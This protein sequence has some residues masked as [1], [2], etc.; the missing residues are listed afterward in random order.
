MAYPRYN[1]YQASESRAPNETERQGTM[2]P[3][4][5]ILPVILSGGAG[6]RLWPISRRH[7]PKQ[8]L[9]I[10]SD[11]PLI[12]D[13]VRRV[14]DA[15]AFRPPM[16]IANDAHRF[17]I[18]QAMRD[19]ALPCGTIALEP[20]GRNTAAS[21]CTAALIAAQ[22]GTDPLLLVLPSDHLIADPKA[23][24]SAIETGR[25]AAEAGYLTVFGIEPSAPETG[26]GYIKAGDTLA[27]APG[28]MHVDTFIEKPDPTRAATLLS[29]GGWTW[30]SGMFLLRA[31]SAIDAFAVHAP[32]ILA[33]CTE[34]VANAKSD[35]D[36]LRLGTAAWNDIP[37]LPFD[38]AVMEKTD[39][40]CVVPADMGWSDIGTWSAL[41]AIGVRDANGNVTRGDIV[42]CESNDSLAV[43]DGPLVALLGIDNLAVI[44]T[45]DAVLV[46]PK[47]RAQD[48]KVLVDKLAQAGRKELQTSA[49]VYRPWGHYQDIDAGP[50]FRTKRLVIAPGQ[51]LSKQ[52]HNRRA[53][54]WVV[55]AGTATVLKGED[56]LTVE[57]NQSVYIPVGTIHSLAN[58]GAAPLQVIEVQTG[59]YLEEDDIERFED[60]YGRA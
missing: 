44:A 4:D 45:E 23:F 22:D 47:G 53:E 50:G 12:I 42:A 17:M 2:T 10:V 3:S 51:R 55:V 41:S 48:V 57:E 7:R 9:P 27:Q 49:V 30:N 56:T 28:T 26:Y 31:S 58:N 18:A 20:S 6:T 14:S 34:A 5:K 39:R 15:G 29:A 60:L 13:T 24:L 52:R 11:D 16:F 59:D 46:M 35:L 37:A 32:E 38:K 8:F 33:G 1:V 40:A 25:S 43:S 54:H 36:F 19:A 21:L